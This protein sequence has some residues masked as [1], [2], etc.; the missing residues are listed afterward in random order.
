MRIAILGCG[1]VGKALARFWS[2]KKEFVLTC[3]TRSKENI[4]PLQKITQRS[5]LLSGE[6][7]EEMLRLLQTNDIILVTVAADSVEDYKKTYLRTAQSI[8]YAASKLKEKKTLFYTSSASVYGDHQGKWVDETSS[9]LTASQ[10]GKILVETEKEYLSLT[11][12]G[13]KVTLFRLAEIY[14]PGRDLSQ[15]VRHLQGR[16]LPGTG[17]YF[18]NM[19]H[20]EDIVGVIHH[21]LTHH[22]EGLFNLADDD[23]PTRK[24]FYNKIADHLD[25]SRIVWDPQLT[26]LNRGNK[27]VSNHAI[28]S[29]GYTFIHPHRVLHIDS[30]L[31]KESV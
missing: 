30:S 15:R 13:W 21:A 17:N 25:L 19:V 16:V 14:G 11:S 28:K 20:I 3:T 29:S 12:L 2:L 8:H 5:F 23:H 9:L 24:E 6:N 22:L 27:K 18:T 10:E 4:A 7:Q 31:E 1:Y 26:R